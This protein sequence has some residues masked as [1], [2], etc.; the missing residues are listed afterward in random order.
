M[1][2]GAIVANALNFYPAP[3][4]LSVYAQRTL[5]GL[6]QRLGLE[7][8]ALAEGHFGLQR[9]PQGTLPRRLNSR[10]A[11]WVAAKAMTQ[12]VTRYE[13]ELAAASLIYAPYPDQLW[14]LR[15]Q[16]QVITC[17]DLTPLVYPNSAAAHWYV[18]T[19]QLAA[20]RAATRVIAISRTVA[21]HLHGHGVPARQIEVI[22]NGVPPATRCHD[23][24][25]G[26]DVVLL[27]RHDRNKN[28]LLALQ[29][30]A[31]FLARNPHWPG[32]LLI[33]GREGRC[34]PQ[35]RQASRA[36]NLESRISWLASLSD[37]HLAQILAQAFCLLSCSLMEGFDFPL[38]E[39]QAMGLPTLASDIPVHRE[40][41]HDASLLFRV[42][43]QGESLAQGLHD[44]AH[45]ATLWQQL[46]SLGSTNASRY[47]LDRQA[48]QISQLLLSV[49]QQQRRNS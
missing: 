1:T 13:P 17:H 37:Q 49:Q 9:Y 31:R 30:F 43:D 21:D 20:C 10:R 14:R 38:L 24:P 4:G 23:S 29:G 11:A 19:V 8:L 33:I 47:T 25:Q 26:H 36:L 32:R 28:V 44:I 2:R 15:D 22:A 34:T 40:L 16:P 46:S 27:A 12:F 39:A 41:H 35:L 45:S 3:T 48:D 42:D 18:K 7:V 5:A 6:A